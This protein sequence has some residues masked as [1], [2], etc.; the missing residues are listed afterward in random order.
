[1]SG[2]YSMSTVLT[3]EPYIDD[4]SRLFVERMIERV[5]PGQAIDLG[6]WFLWYAYDVI[7]ELF[8]GRSLGFIKNHGD[9]GAFLESLEF[10]LPVMT[11]AAVSTPLVRGLIM[12]LFMLSSTARTGLQGMNLIIDT[13]RTSVDERNAATASPGKR[14]RKDLLHYLLAI[15]RAK[16]SEVDFGVEDVKNEAFA[17]LIVL[18]EQIRKEVDQAV[19]NGTL[20]EYPSYSEV[21]QLPLVKSAIKE[22]LRL[23]SGMGFTMPRVVGQS[24]IELA[25]MHIPAGCKVGI[26]PA[27]VGRD[28]A[29]Y[30]PDADTC[31]DLVFGAGT[32]TCIG[33]QIAL[34]EIY[35][36]VPL[37]IRK[38]EFELVN[39][40]KSW[41]TH[42]YFFNKQSGVQVTVKVRGL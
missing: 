36:F 34:S 23:H 42:D 26:N 33:K 41:T 4:C 11:P 9:Q 37:M 25:G 20:S 17:A 14:E 19:E 1:M 38:F 27:V 21:M 29:A 39:P 18:Y 16:G 10:M 6:D 2:I 5:G 32:R 8:F 22:A 31:N 28:E 15:V 30:G 40:S 12:G 3:L 24:G 35:K 13:A 7:A